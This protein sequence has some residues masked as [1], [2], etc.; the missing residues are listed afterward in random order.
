[1]LSR[2]I[3]VSIPHITYEGNGKRTESWIGGIK[4]RSYKY[5]IWEY[6]LEFLTLLFWVLV[7]AGL[8]YI[9]AHNDKIRKVLKNYKE[10]GKKHSK[11]SKKNYIFMPDAKTEQSE[12]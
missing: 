12:E 2:F 4:G 3:E 10:K 5:F 9:A 11:T 6:N 7:L 1:M 8:I